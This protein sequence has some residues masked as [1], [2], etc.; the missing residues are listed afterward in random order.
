MAAGW[1]EEARRFL[2]SNAGAAYIRFL[3]LSALLALVLGIGF[4]ELAQRRYEQNKREEKVTALQLVDAFFAEYSEIRGG[5]LHG[6]APVPASYRAHAI[7]RF[8]R[9]R[10]ADVLRL[11]LAGPA[12]REIA[13]S[14]VDP[15]LAAT[16]E[17]FRME[18]VP[19]PSTEIVRLQGETLLRT[20]VP[21]I[22]QEQS[23]VDCHNE[24]QAGRVEWRL[25][26]VMGAYAVD[27]PS[28]RSR[29]S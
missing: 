11:H 5:Q 8:N 3:A 14:P 9:T 13:T 26:D 27:I 25:G 12:G 19:R 10:G 24:R 20:V 29:C 15:H 16:I 17:R 22:A 1:K 4:F 2:R 21:S 7:G 18:A 6:Q 23:C 28:S